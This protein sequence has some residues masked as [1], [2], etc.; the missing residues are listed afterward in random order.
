MNEQ[1]RAYM[2]EIGRK[3][4]KAG[5]GASKA[6]KTARKAAKARWA[7]AKA[8]AAKPRLAPEDEA[9]WRSIMGG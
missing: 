4:G 7:K 9:F 2:A 5:M 6:R 1:L 3:G 8:K